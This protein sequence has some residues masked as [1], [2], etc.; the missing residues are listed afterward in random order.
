MSK[1]LAI[2]G[3]YRV[4][5]ITD[6]TVQT[7]AEALQEAGAEVEIIYLREYPIEFC[8]NCRECTQEL[9]DDPAECAQDDGMRAL[10]KKLE[11]AD[12]YILASPTNVGSVTAVFKRF[13]ERLLVYVY[14]PWDREIPKLRKGKKPKKK[15]VLLSS[16][17]AP[18]LMGRF[19]YHTQKELKQT[20]K[21]TGARPVGTLFTGHISK[22]RHPVLQDKVKKKARMLA[23]KLV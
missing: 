21:M 17:A 18:G 15:A 23:L 6:Q 11:E 2:N 1:I 5:G 19:L 13:M 9:G 3:S 7:M 12:G 22:D 4:D 20:A 16:C 8:L 14:W 10:I